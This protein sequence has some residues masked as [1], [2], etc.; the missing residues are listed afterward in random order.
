MSGDLGRSPLRWRLW[1]LLRSL[2]EPVSLPLSPLV[3]KELSIL[4]A[5]DAIPALEA[6]AAAHEKDVYV[7]YR[8][9][10]AVKQLEKFAENQNALIEYERYAPVQGRL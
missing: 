10:R 3:P 9:D 1:T 2:T 5:V 4:C 6:A 8:C 7:R